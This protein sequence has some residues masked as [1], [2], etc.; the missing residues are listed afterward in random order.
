MLTL[1]NALDLIQDPKTFDPM[2]QFQWTLF[3]LSNFPLRTE[4][5]EETKSCI[6]MYVCVYIYI[7]I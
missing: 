6:D 5:V 7:Y 4:Y 2:S 3:L 1:N